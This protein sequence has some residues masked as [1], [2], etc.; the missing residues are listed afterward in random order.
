MRLWPIIALIFVCTLCGNGAATT[1]YVDKDNT[2][3]QDG[4]SWTTAFQTIQAGVDAAYNDSGGEVWVAEG[5]YTATTDDSVVVMKNGVHIYGGFKGICTS[6]ETQR[7]QRNWTQHVTIING[8]DTRRCVS[9]ADNA[10]LDGFTITQGYAY[11][12]SA[13]YN[14]DTSTSLTIANCIFSNNAAPGGSGGAIYNDNSSPLLTNCVFSNN[15]IVGELVS[16][17]DPG[18][19]VAIRDEIGKPTGPIRFSD[20]AMIT[21]LDASGQGIVDLEGIQYCTNLVWLD[22]GGNAITDLTPLCGTSL[23][24]LNLE[25]NGLTDA[26]ISPLACLT[27]LMFLGL[28][29]NQFVDIGCLVELE[30]LLIV[31]VSDN[32]IVDIGWLVDLE[33]L[34]GVLLGDNYSGNNPLSEESICETIPALE[35]QGVYVDHWSRQLY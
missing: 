5:T 33:N 10:T 27:S 19:E 16:F 11:E 17:T 3:T 25:N 21:S 31:D 2:G 13:I 1:W 30:N 4:E 24:A 32:Q 18:L 26:D 22:L 35:A 34:L 15:T 7:T 20:V 6:P 29:N 9:G 23:H 28:N 12:G 14:H 8:Q